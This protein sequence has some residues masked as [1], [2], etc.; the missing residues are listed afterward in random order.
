MIDTVVT[1]VRDATMELESAGRIIAAELGTIFAKRSGGSIESLKAY[2]D[3]ENIVVIT[4]AGPLVYT[5]AGEYHFHLSMA[6]L[7]IK[8]LKNGKPDHMAVAMDLFPGASVLDCT[9]GL[10]TDAIVASYCVGISGKVKGLE[11]S[12]LIAMV[13]KYGLQNYSSDLPC[14]N[15]ALRR[16]SVTNAD[17]G[18][19]LA[20]FPDNSFDVVYFDPMFRRPVHESSNMKPIRCLAN[21]G[22]LT[23]EALHEAQRVAR[24]RVVIK[25]KR[26]SGEF[27]RLGVDTVVGGKYS[28]INYGIIQAGG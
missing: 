14:I 22:P 26:G 18:A 4:K 7:R 28:S 9:L 12:P 15:E 5:H 3:A 10:A 19:Q 23:V 11:I 21:N 1:T 6:E 24:R 8:N 20:L 17:Y 2:Y 16:I 13:S 25:E 27:I